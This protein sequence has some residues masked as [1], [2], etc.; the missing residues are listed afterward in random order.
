MANQIILGLQSASTKQSYCRFVAEFN[1][2]RK[3]KPLSEGLLLSFLVEQSKTKAASTLWTMYSLIKKYMALECGFDLGHSPQ[4]SNFLKTLARMHLKKKAP[5]FSREELFMFLRT[6]PSESKVLICKLV[7]LVGFY[8]GLRCSEMV[9]LMWKDLVFTEEGILITIQKSKTDQAGIGAVKLIP[10]MKEELLCPVFYFLKYKAV[11]NGPTGRLFRVVCNGR[12]TKGPMGKNTI[13]CFPKD[14]AVF[15]GLE[16]PQTY[17]GHSL[18][19]SSATVLADEGGDNLVL[20][21][22]GRWSSDAIAEDY[23]RNSKR[24]RIDTANLLGGL[25]LLPLTFQLKKT[26]LVNH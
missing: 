1:L 2:F 11:V 19:V 9:A 21:R 5:A 3:E 20:K 15:L 6:A 8:G 26:T 18:R 25:V 22:H 24:C 13:S 14:I 17:T 23:V 10:R 12:F 16:N 7:L 4:I